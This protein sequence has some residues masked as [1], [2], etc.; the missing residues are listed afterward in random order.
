MKNKCLL[1]VI[2]I[3]TIGSALRAQEYRMPLYDEEIPLSNGNVITEKVT[4]EEII[5]ISQDRLAFFVLDAQ[6]VFLC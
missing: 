1:L 4:H 6:G 3:V 5:R 2:A